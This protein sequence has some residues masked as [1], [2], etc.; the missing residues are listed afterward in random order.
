[1]DFQIFLTEMG[2]LTFSGNGKPPQYKALTCTY[3][4]Y[5][6]EN[7][8]GGYYEYGAIVL[9]QIEFKEHFLELK[10]SCPS[11]QYVNVN[12]DYTEVRWGFA[13]CPC[14]SLR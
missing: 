4:S 14:V 11:T 10:S 9:R 3:Q 5:L 12:I 13:Q 7:G 2:N 6:L 1:M 8:A